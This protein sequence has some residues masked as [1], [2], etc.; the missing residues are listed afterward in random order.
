MATPVTEIAY[1]TLKPNTDIS[2]SSD[3][4]KAWKEGLSVIAKQEGYQ[5]SSYGR[6][7]ESP[8]LLMW[9]IGTVPFHS[10]SWHSSSSPKPIVQDLPR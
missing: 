10:A 3:A 6:A 8:D 2:G 4:A 5:G 9:F 1:I 7:I